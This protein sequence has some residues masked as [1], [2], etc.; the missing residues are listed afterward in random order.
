V[1]DW[2]A[3]IL[4]AVSSVALK[5]SHALAAT[6]IVIAARSTGSTSTHAAHSWS[7]PSAPSGYAARAVMNR[8]DGDV[9]RCNRW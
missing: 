3:S 9:I 6:L 4:A 1:I 2:C 5:G 7:G 8:L